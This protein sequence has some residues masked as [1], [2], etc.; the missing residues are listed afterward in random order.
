M[1]A[2]QKHYLTDGTLFK[3]KSHMMG[4]GVLHSGANHTAS[5][6]ILKHY[7]ELSKKA[8]AKARSQWA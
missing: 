2:K 3:G 8:K 4:N 5:S 1:G 7:G 6:K